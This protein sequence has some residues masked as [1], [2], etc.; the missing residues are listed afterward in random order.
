MDRHRFPLE[1]WRLLETGYDRSDLGTTE[2]LFAVG[3]GYL[4]MRANPEEGRDSYEHG[5]FI[6]GFHETWPIRHAEEAFGFAQTGQTIVNAPDAK[7]MK[8]YIDDEP[9]LLAIADL[10]SYERSLDFRE[11]VLRRHLVW[12][13]PSGKRV[14]VSSTRMVSFA[15]RHLA[16]MTLDI[17]MLDATAPVVVS[18]QIINRQDG[19]GGC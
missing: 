8:L 4:G 3:N 14:R 16:V 15:E 6:N 18:S 17:E 9:L 13:T 10:E 12:V 7:T 19:L 1:E 2:S 11:G 5:T